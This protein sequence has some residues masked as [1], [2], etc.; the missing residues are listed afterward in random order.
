MARRPE[1][2]ITAERRAERETRT[3]L[4]EPTRLA[5]AAF[6]LVGRSVASVPPDNPAGALQANKVARRL[7]LRLSNDLRAA[8]RLAC[9]GYAVQ[10][11]ALMAGLYET[12]LTIIHVG[13]DETRALKWLDHVDPLTVPWKAKVLTLSVAARLGGAK[14]KQ[15]AN[16]LYQR[17]SQFCMFK[18]G[19]PQVEMQHVTPT[20][21]G[22]LEA[23]NGPDW[24]ERSMRTAW[25][26][27]LHGV[28]LALLAQGPFVLDHVPT[29]RR[30]DELLKGR[31]VIDRKRNEL[32]Q[33][34]A[35]R[36]PGGDPFPGKWARL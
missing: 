25:F 24:S 19:N 1:G 33:Q 12:A 26:A 30:H 2:L 34:A 11:A 5:D 29:G 22:V 18:H 20:E 23:S 17:Y 9:L 4:R 10:A 21:P 3:L 36:W 8:S 31:S 32:S 7:M 16:T 28:G 35:K 6:N 15:V 27:L 13:A 14:A